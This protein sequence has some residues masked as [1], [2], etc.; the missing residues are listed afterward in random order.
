MYSHLNNSVF[1]MY[2]SRNCY[3]GLSKDY[4][5]MIKYK[6]NRHILSKST[7]YE[8]CLE[9]SDKRKIVVTTNTVT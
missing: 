7:R 3:E 5:N 9:P 6:G 2:M 8:N 1:H 4:T